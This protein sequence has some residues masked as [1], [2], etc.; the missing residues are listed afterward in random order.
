M[1]KSDFHS[2]LRYG[3]GER[4]QGQLGRVRLS[5][6]ICLSDSPFHRCIALVRTL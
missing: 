4:I 1:I 5:C 3:L 6:R 2:A